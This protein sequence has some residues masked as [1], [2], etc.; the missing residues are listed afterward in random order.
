[1]PIAD[2]AEP[3]TSDGGLLPPR[4]HARRER[5]AF[6][7][8]LIH[9]FHRLGGVEFLVKFGREH[10]AD[11]VRTCA[12]LI[13]VEVRNSGATQLTII[14]ALPPTALDNHPGFEAPTIHR[15]TTAEAERDKE[16]Q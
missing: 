4:G 16:L 13:P 6:K 8:A 5:Q 15:L 7:D 10:P 2:P 11:F 1:M 9:A 12:R 14:H 3:P